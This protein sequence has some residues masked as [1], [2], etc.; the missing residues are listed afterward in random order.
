[1]WRWRRL[2]R[3]CMSWWSSKRRSANAS[4]HQ[5]S[6]E[7]DSS[8]SMGRLSAYA[9]RVASSRTAC[10]PAAKNSQP[11]GPALPSSRTRAI[12]LRS[13]TRTAVKPLWRGPAMV[14]TSVRL[15]GWVHNL[16]SGGW[17]PR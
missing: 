8:A 3:R 16:A 10:S 6:N 17:A 4:L 2:R 1:M 7:E 15:Y 14:A 12:R 5:E 13:Q 9:S 11:S